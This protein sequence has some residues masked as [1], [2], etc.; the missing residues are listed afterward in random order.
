MALL[1]RGYPEAVWMAMA[2]SQNQ[3][4]RALAEVRVVYVAAECLKPLI[5]GR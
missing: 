1:Q 4:A 2:Q 3:Q 5:E